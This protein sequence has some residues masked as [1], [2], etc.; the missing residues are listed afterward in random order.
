[1]S[2]EGRELGRGDGQSKKQAEI[3]A[4]SDALR[5]RAWE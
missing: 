4:A 1:V 5:R 2:W 3:N